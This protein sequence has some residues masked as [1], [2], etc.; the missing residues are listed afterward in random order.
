MQYSESSSFVRSIKRLPTQRK[1]LVKESISKLVN[2]FE[3]KQL[4]KGLGLKQLRPN[5]WEARAG[6]ADRIVFR[7]KQDTIEFII[8]GTHDEIKRLLKNL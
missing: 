5:V 1:E 6:L 2:F 7:R 4:P 8:V 3:S